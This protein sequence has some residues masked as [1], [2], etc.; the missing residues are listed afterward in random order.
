MKIGLYHP[1]IKGKGG[2]EKVLLEIAENSSHEIEIFTLYYNREKTFEGFKDIEITVL[3]SNKEPRG[4]I[5]KGIRFGLGALTT[6]LPEEEYDL[7]MVSEA[8]IGSL[9]TLRNHSKPILCYCHT[10][11]RPALPE[12]RETYLE[13][14]DFISSI[15]YRFGTKFYSLLESRAWKKFDHVIANSS[16]TEGRILNKGLKSKEKLS[17][18]NPGA[19]VEENNHESYDNYF[20]Y[21][22]RF[23]RYKRQEMAIEAFEKADLEDLK[24]VLAGAGQ[25]KDYIEELKEKAGENVEFETDVSGERWD[26]LYANSYSVLFC[27]EKEDWG[28][29]PVEAASYSKPVIS[30]NEGGPQESVLDG[31]TGFLE[32]SVEEIAEKMKYLAERPEKVSEIGKK[33]RKHSEKY[34]W[35]KFTDE[36]DERI[37]ALRN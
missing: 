35:I 9:I 1:W 27:A 7:L 30:V 11:L 37:E 17:V 22:S 28:I 10:P 13:E 8:G 34:S 18:L 36:L 3:G 14:Q 33:A 19:D 24:L 29:I 2:V 4:F 26:E 23:R 16:V 6:K 5:D 15:I 32:D 21:P 25:E 31:E 20:L 12:F